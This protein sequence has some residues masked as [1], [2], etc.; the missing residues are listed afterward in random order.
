MG[1]LLYDVFSIEDI[2]SLSIANGETFTETMNKMNYL[3]KSVELEKFYSFYGVLGFDEQ[4]KKLFPA[5]CY[6][7]AMLDCTSKKFRDFLSKYQKAVQ[8]ADFSKGPTFKMN[9]MRKKLEKLEK[10][11]KIAKFTPENARKEMAKGKTKIQEIDKMWEEYK[12]S[13]NKNKVLSF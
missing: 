4:G 3:E 9:M 2:L 10:R 6:R 13:E 5:Y 8:E 1:K 11:E 12:N 7:E